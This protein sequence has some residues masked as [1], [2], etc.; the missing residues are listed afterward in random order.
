MTEGYRKIAGLL[1]FFVAYVAT[2][3]ALWGATAWV[4]I[5]LSIIVAEV[6]AI[7]VSDWLREEGRK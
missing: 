1:T 2:S 7:A 3:V 6:C 5:I 4:R